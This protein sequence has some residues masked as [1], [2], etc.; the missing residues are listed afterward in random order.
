MQYNSIFVYI[1][2]K[3]IDIY[4]ELLLLDIFDIQNLLKFRLINKYYNHLIIY[5][6]K[7][8][9][10]F[11]II[12]FIQSKYGKLSK[13]K[14]IFELI[15]QVKYSNNLEFLIYLYNIY[16]Q[17][18]RFCEIYYIINAIYRHDSVELACYFYNK[19]PL[20]REFD[21]YYILYSQCC[22]SLICSFVENTEEIHK[23]L[24]FNKKKY[25]YAEFDSILFGITTNK[26]NTIQFIKKYGI[27][28]K[29]L[30]DSEIKKLCYIYDSINIFKK[31]CL[32]E[33]LD[34]YNSIN[35]SE[36]YKSYNLL[37]LLNERQ[38]NSEK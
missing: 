7:I 2:K 33:T 38:S 10:V 26:N 12:N 8:N 18:N 19:I 31:F 16:K 23:R 15:K 11:D 6:S 4:H 21:I 35:Y 30:I 37:N 9:Y 24:K 1:T 13:K 14:F 36:C 34:I 17:N 29:P 22:S 3:S 27:K 25:D 28:I 20:Y 32:N 5:Y